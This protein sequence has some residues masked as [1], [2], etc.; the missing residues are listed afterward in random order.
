MKHNL[1]SLLTA[2]AL[3]ASAIGAVAQG[4]AFTY[5]GQLQNNG[6]PANGT[7]D[8]RLLVYDSSTGG[9]ILGGPITNI[10]VVVSN[11]LFTTIMDFGA[12]VFT[13]GSNWLHIGVRTNGSGVFNPLSP[14]QQLTP[15]PYAIYSES[16]GIATTADGVAAGVVSAAQ[17]NTPGAPASGQVL[18]YN[19]S[20]L[21]WVNP[22]TA[23]FAWNLTGN[24]GTTPGVNFLGTTDNTPLDLEVNGERGLHLEYVSRGSHPPLLFFQDAVNVI[25]GFWGNIVSNT[26]S[27]GPVIGG[28]V[29]GAA[30]L[31][32]F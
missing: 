31:P 1:K 3:L 4:T 14:R 17:L 13:G 22:A 26:V 8:F 25:G 18:E 11:G 6:G 29:A 16:A 32:G 7:Y 23:A 24:A 30:I 9:S 21:T 10:G 19:G 5:Q 12:G 28:T 2:L 15:T 20:S 27:G